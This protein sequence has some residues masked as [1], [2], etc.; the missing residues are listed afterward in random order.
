MMN[1]SIQRGVRV[2]TAGGD[3]RTASTDPSRMMMRQIAG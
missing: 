3:D 1:A 2:L